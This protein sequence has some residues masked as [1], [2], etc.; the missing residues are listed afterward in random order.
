MLIFICAIYSSVK[1]ISGN[2]F[3]SNVL[4]LIPDDLVPA[5]NQQ[6]KAQLMKQ[7]EQK[8][9]VLLKGEDSAQGLQLAQ[10]LKAQLQLVTDVTISESAA[11]MGKAIKDF[12]FPFRYQLLSP[13]MRDQLLALSPQHLAENRWRTMVGPIR[14]YAPYQFEDDPFNLGGEWAQSI[15][16]LGG[17]FEATEIFSVR[18][19]P[20]N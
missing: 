2:G 4:S 5:E 19:G 13:Q 1:V 14:S 18:D 9:I 20:D 8:F 6:V 15:A 7:V 3:E 12:Y 11:Q 10:M 16:S 17:R